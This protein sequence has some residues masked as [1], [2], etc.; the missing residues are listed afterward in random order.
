M[1]N[2]LDLEFSCFNCNEK[3]FDN[4]PLI[5]ADD[6]NYCQECFDDMFSKCN[7][8]GQ[9][10]DKE[11]L[12]DQN[13]AFY[14]DDCFNEKFFSCYNCGDVQ[15]INNGY[16]GVD[17]ENYCQECFN[18][19]F[20]ICCCCDE[21][22]FNDYSYNHDGEMYCGD[23]FSENFT[24]CESCG[25][26]YPNNDM[27]YSENEEMYYCQDCYSDNNCNLINSYSY[28]PD[29][30]FFKSEKD[31]KNTK[32]FFGIE[33]EVENKNNIDPYDICET[34]LENDFIYLKSDSSIENGFEVVT[35]PLSYNFLLE[36]EKTL[37]SI[38]ELLKSEGFRSYNTSTCGIHIH[39]SKNDISHLTLYKMLKL[40]Y[41]NPDFIL[42]ISQRNSGRFKQWSSLDDTNDSLILK[43]KNKNS[44]KRYTAINLKNPETIEFRIFRG[45]LDIKSFFKN[46]EFIKSIVEFCKLSGI[47]DISKK[48]YIDYIYDNKK[49]YKNLFNF[50]N[51][52]KLSE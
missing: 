30:I 6:K 23:C 33:L 4:F 19:M 11:E 51:D 14:C 48:R 10:Y 40:F 43:A 42:K 20:S 21:T 41:E 13:Q 52:K 7:E 47:K 50:I 46:I 2:L 8:C 34:I 29:P 49:Q 26:H 39:I 16:T 1:D 27:C 5:G 44:C 32:E 18:D 37:Q 31:S 12:I 38:F 35:H 28:K 17:N 45:T 24:Y 36:K 3:I 25:E 15:D 22:T 9:I